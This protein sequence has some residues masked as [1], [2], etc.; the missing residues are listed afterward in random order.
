VAGGQDRTRQLKGI[1][2]V[3]GILVLVG[4]IAMFSIQR[5]GTTRDEQDASTVSN[6]ATVS[7]EGVHHTDIREG[8]KEWLLDA[9]YADYRLEQNIAYL[10]MLEASF[11]D[12]NG[13][14]VLLFADSG[15]WKRDSNDLEVSG[16]VVLKNSQ[17][18]MRTDRLL[19]NESEQ[20][21]STT[22]KVEILAHAIRKVADGM[23]YSL[24][25]GNIV[26]EGN[27]EG[28]IGNGIGL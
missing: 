10:K 26:L 12:S 13:E 8:S 20:L 5:T 17:Y 14:T 27:V 4:V 16:N 25:T 1:L 21:F 15:V 28:E 23:T 18:V 19:Y 3:L 22:S 7:L 2:L 9:E 11:F 6:D 24:N